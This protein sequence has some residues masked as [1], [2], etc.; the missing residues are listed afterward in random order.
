MQR[1]ALGILLF[2]LVL[3][4]AIIAGYWDMLESEK[5]R[6]AERRD[7]PAAETEGAVEPTGFS[8]SDR[9]TREP[10]QEARNRADATGE[11]AP[12]P[13]PDGNVAA[14]DGATSP[15]NVPTKAGSTGS[16]REE[17][18]SAEMTAGEAPGSDRI[19]RGKSDRRTSGNETTAGE[20]AAPNE[21]AVDDGTTE[22]SPSAAPADVSRTRDVAALDQPDEMGRTPGQELPRPERTATEPTAP[23]LASPQAGTG[24]ATPPTSVADDEPAA[25]GQSGGPATKGPA[26][27]SVSGVE[28]SEAEAQAAPAAGAGERETAADASQTGVS[29]SGDMIGSNEETGPADDATFAPEGGERIGEAA[30]APAPAQAAQAVGEPA[31]SPATEGGAVG[32]TREQAAPA[33][34]ASPQAESS[35]PGTQTADA[36]DMPRKSG[37]TR[38]Q[39]SDAAATTDEARRA[40]TGAPETSEMI[41][42]PEVNPEAGE[43]SIWPTLWDRQAPME[44]APQEARSSLVG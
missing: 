36:A 30:E 24:G 38:S 31:M 26:T 17:A 21:L 42:A 44:T 22:P 16:G 10:G 3:L 39:A 35:E 5:L 12:Q 23:G 14:A 25:A 43:T 4:V 27:D 18:R 37:E 33:E 20:D 41:E 2:C 9:A 11:A 19:A 13:E 8:G 15:K 34:A 6:I 40:A 29:A 28:P 32:E 1:R 7:N